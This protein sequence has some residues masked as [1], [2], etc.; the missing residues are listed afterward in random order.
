MTKVDKLKIVMPV[1][2]PPI[3]TF[4]FL[5]PYLS[6]DQLISNWQSQA[7]SWY[8]NELHWDIR[9]SNFPIWHLENL[10]LFSFS[11]SD[12]NVDIC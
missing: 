12:E 9:D 10:E 8:I 4:V 3:L 1:I 5:F 6:S 7:N 11:Y 2:S